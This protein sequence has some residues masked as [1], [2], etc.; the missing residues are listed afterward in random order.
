MDWV[1]SRVCSRSAFESG[2]FPLFATLDA[3]A[4]AATGGMSNPGL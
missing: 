3:L 1:A 4:G 2:P